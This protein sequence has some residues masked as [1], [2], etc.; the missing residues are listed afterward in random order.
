VL[1]ECLTSSRPF[2]GDSVEQQI[3]GCLTVPP[4]RPS[5]SRPG[6]SPLLDS[7]IAKGMAK[8]PD[9]RYST[10]TELA[11][12]ARSAV[13]APIATAYADDAWSPTQTRLLD[14]EEAWARTQVRPSEPIA[15]AWSETQ[16]NPSGEL[17]ESEPP[18]PPSWPWWQRRS[19]VIP[20][21]AAVIVAAIAT[22]VIAA[23]RG[24][25]TVNPTAQENAPL[26]GT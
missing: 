21:A 25:Q 10:T 13:T 19:V 23:T 16:T 18:P 11:R 2:P 4:P 5:I 20:I 17:F 14:V 6:I 24:D 12:A 7:V 1:Y 9:Q 22:I 26:N 3:A 15:Q 8:D